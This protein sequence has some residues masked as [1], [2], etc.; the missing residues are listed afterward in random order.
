[1][2]IHAR[3]SIVI[4]RPIREVWSYLE[5]EK[6]NQAWRGQYVNQVTRLT[7]GPIAVGTQ[8]Q[9]T[10]RGGPYVTEITR[11]E[12]P[13]HY[14]W[15]YITYPPGQIRGRDGSY[16]L[17]SLGQRTRFELEE[18]FDT[19][20]LLGTILSFPGSLLGRW[21]V[22]PQLLKRLKRTAESQTTS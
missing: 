14:A 5:D 6:K 20:G 10:M 17:T 4:N 9:G 15:K 7:P 22:G 8:F 19:V 1:M 3:A 13:E 21:V 12:P 18:T 2:A 11:Y 16:H